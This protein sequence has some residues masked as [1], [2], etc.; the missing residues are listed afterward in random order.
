MPEPLSPSLPH[1]ELL[2][3]ADCTIGVGGPS[4]LGGW[5]MTRSLVGFVLGVLAGILGSYF[6]L[7]FT[8]GP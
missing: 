7:I 6:F 5:A 1:G 3:V 8:F 2:S 4:M